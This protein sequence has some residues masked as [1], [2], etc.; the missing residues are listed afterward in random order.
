MHPIVLD[1]RHP[2]TKLI[3]QGYDSK[4]CHPGPERVFAELRRKYWVLRGREAIK[5]LQRE[6]VHCQKWR[7]KPEVLKMADLPAARLRLFKPAFYSTGV[8]CFGPYAVKTGR[9][10]G[11]WLEEGNPMNFCRTRAQTSEEVRESLEKPLQFLFQIYRDNWHKQ[12]IEFHFNPP[13]SPHF[14]GCWEQEIRSL[15]NAL[16][17]TLGSQSVTFEVLQ[18]VLVEIEGILNSKPLGYTSS[19]ASD[20]DPITPNCLLMG[21]PDTSLPRQYTLSPSWSADAD[22]A[23]A[24]YLR[25]NSGGTISN[26]TSQLPRALWPV[27]KVSE[28]YPGADTRVRTDKVQWSEIGRPHLPE[29]S[30][31][32]DA[33]I[34]GSTVDEATRM[35]AFLLDHPLSREFYCVCQHE[36]REFWGSNCLRLYKE[37]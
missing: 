28:V 6:C 31:A 29:T 12:Q 19:N 25:T 22:G 37:A 36:K 16:T 35:M 30:V 14:G 11:S 15:K 23:T 17:A 8:D 13:N 2:I 26:S 1:P 32:V 10:S 4:L 24:R 34:E 20:P 18:T 21:R 33:E 7:K 5:R 3:I 27:G 9:C